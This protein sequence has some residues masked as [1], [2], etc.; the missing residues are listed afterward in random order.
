MRWLAG[1]PFPD[2]WVW[3]TGPGCWLVA[4]QP[5]GGPAFLAERRSFDLPAFA[6]FVQQKHDCLHAAGDERDRDG[7]QAL[8]ASPIVARTVGGCS[9]LQTSGT[10]GS[11]QQAVT[12]AA[13]AAIPGE[14][15]D[16]FAPAATDDGTPGA[17]RLSVAVLAS[18]RGSPQTV[19]TL[20]MAV[21]RAG[22]LGAGGAA[23][24]LEE[25]ARLAAYCAGPVAKAEARARRPAGLPTP[26]ERLLAALAASR[27]NRTRAAA[28]LG[29][30]RQSFIQRLKRH[31]LFRKD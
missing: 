30:S 21:A 7:T 9:T 17:D 16:A 29:V 6:A 3:L 18:A 25:L 24:S 2:D 15:S 8:V 26:R 11:G 14:R 19:A 28:R 31:H 1:F 10:F 13:V 5:E 12:F 22:V 27:G 4:H 23:D 20:A